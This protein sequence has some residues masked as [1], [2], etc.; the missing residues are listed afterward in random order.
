MLPILAR[1]HSS[2]LFEVASEK[3][4]IRKIQLVRNLLHRHRRGFQQRFRIQ[5]HGIVDP[6]EDGLAADTFDERREIFGRHAEFPGIKSHTAFI[7]V[8]LYHQFDQPFADILV[9]GECADL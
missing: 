8:M 9:M 5:D 6:V 2:V 7:T 1:C 3:G 4:G